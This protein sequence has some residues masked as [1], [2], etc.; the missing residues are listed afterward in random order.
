MMTKIFEINYDEDEDTC[1]AHFLET[2]FSFNEEFVVGLISTIVYV[3]MSALAAGEKEQ[4]M[5]KL[6]DLIIEEFRSGN[7]ES[8]FELEE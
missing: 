8:R 7:I 5:A 4:F 2:D 6:E 1:E 3:F